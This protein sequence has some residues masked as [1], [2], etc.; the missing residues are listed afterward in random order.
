MKK[1]M[2]MVLSVVF[3][4]ILSIAG[5]FYLSNPRDVRTEPEVSTSNKVSLRKRDISLRGYCSFFDDIPEDQKR[6]IADTVEDYLLKYCKNSGRPSSVIIFTYE[7]AMYAEVNYSRESPT[8]LLVTVDKD[9]C[10]VTKTELT[11]TQVVDAKEAYIP[12]DA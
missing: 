4:M 2:H 1:I 10:S 6:W 9:H 8:Y 7:G 5:M 3:V 12:A 11:K